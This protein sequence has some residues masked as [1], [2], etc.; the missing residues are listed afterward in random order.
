MVNAR[1]ATQL[2]KATAMLQHLGRAVRASRAFF[3]L[4]DRTDPTQAQIVACHPPL[5][6]E[7]VLRCL[8]DDNV[9]RV[10]VIDDA[11]HQAWIGV[12]CDGAADNMELVQEMTEV[13]AQSMAS[14]L[15]SMTL[16]GSTDSAPDQLTGLPDHN[17]FLAR[18]GVTLQAN[19]V[20]GHRQLAVVLVDLDRYHRVMA[21]FGEIGADSLVR[22][23]VERLKSAP[24]ADEYQLSRVGPDR[25]AFLIHR[26]GAEDEALALASWIHDC[27][28]VPFFVDIE[29]LFVTASIGIALADGQQ[30]AGE[31]VRDADA[32]IAQLNAQGGGRTLVF[33]AGTHNLPADELMRERDIR[34]AVTR[35][36][37]TVFFQPI[38][39]AKGGGLHSF[40]A[41]LRWRNPDEGL[42][43]PSTFLDVLNDIGLIET[44]GRRVIRESC[45]H[46]ARWL[47]LSGSLV[48][49]SVNIVPAQLYADGFADDVAAILQEEHLPEGSLLLEL[50]EEALVHD[51]PKAMQVLEALRRIGVRVMIDDFG[52]GYSS[53]SYLH[54]L[55]VSGIKLDRGFFNA[56]DT[57]PKQREIV[58]TIVHLAHY[59]GM[60]VV[61]EGIETT[62]QWAIIRELNCD[63]AQGFWF[64]QPLDAEHATR[65]LAREL[66]KGEAA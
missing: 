30:S 48:P 62:D 5:P 6:D 66:A 40:E 36:E 1:Y 14:E 56:I 35:N 15:R 33:Q 46:A 60:V 32:A 26:A 42:L 28:R 51:A 4:R 61:A 7:H 8:G 17:T 2:Q 55:P 39:G 38:V 12:V 37:F 50:T 63:L 41:L 20:K 59:M 34:H 18:L 10:P 29:E 64:G 25:F 27:M 3:V 24:K 11:K 57:S 47:A 49:V 53:L 21:R 54:D 65:F 52:T 16:L 43:P 19:D 22:D 44:V 9:V 31:L 45:A 13:V 23:V 58:R